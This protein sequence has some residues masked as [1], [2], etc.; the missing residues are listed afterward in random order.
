MIAFITGITGQDG[1]YLA[2]LLLDKHYEVHG[3]VRRNSSTHL[4]RIEHLRERLTLHWGDLS[5]GLTLAQIIER[6]QPDEVYN[7]GSQSHVHIS[8]ENPVYTADV[9]ATGAVRLLEAVKQ[10]AKKARIYQAGSSEM[11]GLTKPP[12]NE[13]TG[14]HPR[15]VYACSKVFAH[16]AAIQYREA[17]GM[18]ISNGILF[19]H[20]SERRGEN[21]VT[22]KITKAVAAI[23]KQ[24]Q[25]KLMLGD[26]TAMR[27]WGYAKEYVEAMWLM[28]QQ[29]EPDDFVIGTGVAHSV[30]DFV[31]AAFDYV[32]LD[33]ES[34]V[35]TS[36]EFIRPS[37]VHYLVADNSKAK[38]VLNWQPKTTFEQLVQLMVNHD[39]R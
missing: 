5:D 21:F 1:S 18:F 14:F 10:K 16:H 24:R 33:W 28:L 4:A 19:N 9:T 8:F 39:L 6:V 27:D 13:Q 12:L 26:L 20:E 34:H 36:G 17:F 3:L 15:S 22:R 31:K 29:P 7:L 30:A 23:K 37:E 25:E 11:F 38:R 35:E 32:E 2:E